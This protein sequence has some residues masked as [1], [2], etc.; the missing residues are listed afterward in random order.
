MRLQANGI[1]AETVACAGDVAAT[2]SIRAP[3]RGESGEGQHTMSMLFV[4]HLPRHHGVTC[5]FTYFSG[6]ACPF[7]P[8]SHREHPVQHRAWTRSS[9]NCLS[10]AVSASPRNCSL[11][12]TIFLCLSFLAFFFFSPSRTWA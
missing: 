9:A 3:L 4:S 1:D 10:E 6:C 5:S 7:S 11:D 12:L 2:P 8:P